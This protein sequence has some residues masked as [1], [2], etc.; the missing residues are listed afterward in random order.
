MFVEARW[1]IEAFCRNQ[2]EPTMQVE[3]SHDEAEVLRDLL[4][5]RIHELDMEINRT[6]S[7]SFKKQLQELDR[8]MERMLGEISSALGREHL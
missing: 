2:D 1:R 7:L 8:R 4:Q 5:Q 3:L 6:D